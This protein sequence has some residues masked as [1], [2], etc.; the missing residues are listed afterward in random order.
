[1]PSASMYFSVSGY[2]GQTLALVF[3][4]NYW[5]TVDTMIFFATY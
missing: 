3:D 4:I 2:P 1:M 5:V